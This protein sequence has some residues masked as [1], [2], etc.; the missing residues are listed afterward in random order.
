VSIRRVSAH[1]RF[2]LYSVSQKCALT[3][4]RF[5]RQEFGG[6]KWLSS[7]SPLSDN[8]SQPFVSGRASNNNNHIPDKTTLVVDDESDES[9]EISP[10]F[11]FR[12]SELDPESPAIDDATR[13]RSLDPDGRVAKPKD[14][15]LRLTLDDDA[16]L[17]QEELESAN[18]GAD[19]DDDILAAA[20]T[21]LWA[22]AGKL[23]VAIDV[24][25]GKPVVHKVKEGSP[26]EGFLKKGDI[27]KAIDEVD[28]THMSAADITA[29]M[30]RRMN[31]R[32]KITYIPC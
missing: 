6:L 1:Q 27:L 3:A 12:P 16:F 21:E 11:S 19:D 9:L 25:E 30:V 24:V 4:L 23:S 22:P 2:S 28:T 29:L 13:Q 32:R 26:L 14:R 10:K 18:G 8:A 5:F 15:R 7:F 20:P 31:Q 17:P